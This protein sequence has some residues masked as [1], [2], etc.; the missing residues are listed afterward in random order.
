MGGR[1]SSWPRRRWSIGRSVSTSMRTVRC[2][3][4]IP[5]VR[6]T[7]RMQNIVGIPFTSTGEPIYTGTFISPT[8]PGWRDGLTHAIYGG[9]YGPLNGRLDGIPRTG[10][11]LPVLDEF[12]AAAP[13]GIARLESPA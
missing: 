7:G 13:C 10:E 8:R 12:G 5:A 3:C 4:L 11:L 9:V 2:M 1:L 6:T